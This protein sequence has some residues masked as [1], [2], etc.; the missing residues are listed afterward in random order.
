MNAATSQA[1]ITATTSNPT[2]TSGKAFNVR[3]ADRSTHS[4]CP[5]LPAR[6]TADFGLA[7]PPMQ[8]RRPSTYQT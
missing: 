1:A 4:N 5:A 6:D 3:S 7:R 2:P 8:R